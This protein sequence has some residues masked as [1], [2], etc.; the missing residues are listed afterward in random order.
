[1]LHACAQR[2]G[3]GW[4]HEALQYMLPRLNRQ[5]MMPLRAW[6]VGPRAM[7]G[8]L[9]HDH[10]DKGVQPPP[11][12]HISIHVRTFVVDLKPSARK[13]ALS[14]CTARI[15]ARRIQELQDLQGRTNMSIFIASDSAQ[16]K[17]AIANVLRG[18]GTIYHLSSR[19]G[20]LHSIRFIKNASNT[21]ES[22]D[23]SHASSYLD[24]WALGRSHKLVVLTFAR[25]S[26]PGLAR[27]VST[28]SSTAATRGGVAQ[29][30]HVAITECSDVW[31]G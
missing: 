31:G 26:S 19:L 2:P 10:S 5:T 4:D 30:L 8:A 28:F 11:L 25:G 6:W 7:F 20:L 21:T 22:M 12:F 16:A 9:L 17:E 18:A 24:W 3:K 23:V 13:T 29:I 27:N 15:A 1:M 14:D